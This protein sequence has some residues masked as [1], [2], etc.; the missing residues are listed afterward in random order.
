VSIAS[1]TPEGF[2]VRCSVC[3]VESVVEPS[4]PPGDAVCSA[5]GSLVWSPRAFGFLAKLCE[6]LNVA[7]ESLRLDARFDDDLGLHSLEFVELVMLLEE[8]FDLNVP[9]D[10]IPDR[11]RTLGDFLNWLDRL[12]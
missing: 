4:I 1:R 5:C 6:H 12:Q 2:P 7:P 3:G 10:A 11:W 9:D 8:S